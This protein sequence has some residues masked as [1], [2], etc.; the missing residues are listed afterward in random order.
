MQYVET[1]KIQSCD[2]IEI[3]YYKKISDSRDGRRTLSGKMIDKKDIERVLSLLSA[4]PDSGEMMISWG[5]VPMMEVRLYEND[6]Y[7]IISYFNSRIKTPA[8][9][10]FS[11][12]PAEEKEFYNFLMNYLKK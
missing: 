6:E 5:P 3:R 8:T 12:P 9:S 11:N 10:F 4:L 1:F 2:R 7:K